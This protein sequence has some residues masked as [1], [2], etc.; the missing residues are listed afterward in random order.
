M[1]KGY[2]RTPYIIFLQLL[3]VSSYSKV[4]S[5]VKWFCFFFQKSTLPMGNSVDEPQK[6][7]V[8]ERWQTQVYTQKVPEKAEP[9][10]SY[11]CRHSS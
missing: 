11:R 5:L 10:S 4:K 1:D 9:I 8:S 2:L 7:D 6:Y 3:C